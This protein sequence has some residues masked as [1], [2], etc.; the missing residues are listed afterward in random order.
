MNDCNL[1]ESCEYEFD[2]SSQDEEIW[3]PC[4]IKSENIHT[5]YCYIPELD[6]YTAGPRT[7]YRKINK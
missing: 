1:I 2:Y 4:I 3:Y 5:V 7:L 6:Q